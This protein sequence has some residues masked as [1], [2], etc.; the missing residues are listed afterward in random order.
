M[1]SFGLGLLEQSLFMSVYSKVF[2]DNTDKA[3]WKMQGF[4]F[5]LHKRYKN[6]QEKD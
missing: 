4:I 3:V 5:I 1:K 2:G 6:N